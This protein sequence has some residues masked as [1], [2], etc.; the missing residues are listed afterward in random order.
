MYIVHC[1]SYVIPMYMYTVGGRCT[2]RGVIPNHLWSGRMPHQVCQHMLRR[3][4]WAEVGLFV[5]SVTP[6]PVL[7]VHVHSF[8]SCSSP[9]VC[10]LYVCDFMCTAFWQNVRC[11]KVC[12]CTCVSI[13]GF[14]SVFAGLTLFPSVCVLQVW[15][16]PS[17]HNS[18][19]EDNKAAQHSTNWYSSCTHTHTHARTH[20]RT[21]THTHTHT[22]THAV[23]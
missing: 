13:S 1:S 4:L 20:A 12:M 9:Y 8:C 21:H 2:E 5:M 7:Y 10:T 3:D 14:I 18:S 15:I 16:S 22:S 23:L 6:L 11:S 19:Q 17:Q